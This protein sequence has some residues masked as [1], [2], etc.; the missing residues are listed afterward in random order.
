MKNVLVQGERY[1]KYNVPV[2]ANALERA[3]TNT[4]SPGA[5][6]GILLRCWLSASGCRSERSWSISEMLKDA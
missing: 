5:G 1:S 2:S 4:A 6:L 3:P